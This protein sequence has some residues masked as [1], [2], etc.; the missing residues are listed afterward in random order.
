MILKELIVLAGKGY[1]DGLDRYFDEELV[2]E[3]DAGDTLAEFIVRELVG[4]FD[5][6][7]SGEAQLD[8]AIRV[9]STAVQELT[10]VV[11][12]LQGARDV[13]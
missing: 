10:S 12:V 4:T 8:E 3:V 11:D 6:N 1:P 13:V 7:A 2:E 9:M 5:I